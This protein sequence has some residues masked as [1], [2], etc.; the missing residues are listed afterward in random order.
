[1]TTFNTYSDL[2]KSYPNAQYN[3]INFNQSTRLWEYKPNE[4]STEIVLLALAAV[5]LIL[6]SFTIFTNC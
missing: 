2:L 5:L 3:Q 1:M 4:S 6:I